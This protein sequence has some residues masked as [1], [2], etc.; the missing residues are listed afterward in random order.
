MWVWGNGLSPIMMGVVISF[1]F[2]ESELVLFIHIHN[3]NP[4]WSGMLYSQNI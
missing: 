4:L 2:Q 3:V 1:V